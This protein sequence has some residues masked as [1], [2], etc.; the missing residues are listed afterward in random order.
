MILQNALTA[1]KDGKV[2]HERDSYQ[3]TGS[4][5]TEFLTRKSFLVPLTLNF[6][7]RMRIVID[8]FAPVKESFIARNNQKITSIFA[9][10]KDIHLVN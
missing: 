3:Y 10:W 2:G 5:P 9:G 7:E 6:L 8:F 1:R 4:Q